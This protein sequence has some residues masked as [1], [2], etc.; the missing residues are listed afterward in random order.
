MTLVIPLDPRPG[1]HNANQFTD[2]WSHELLQD[3]W[4][5]FIEEIRFS[6]EPMKVVVSG[7]Y[8]P[9]HQVKSLCMVTLSTEGGEGR[10]TMMKTRG[11]IGV[12]TELSLIVVDVREEDEIEFLRKAG[13][14][15]KD[16]VKAGE[17]DEILPE[18]LIHRQHRTC[19]K[20]GR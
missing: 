15:P 10:R 5:P 6:N 9:M 8:A 1:C 7:L 2:T 4:V 16:I 17:D 12:D 11:T 3:K 20:L 19:W 18:N 14:I 13:K